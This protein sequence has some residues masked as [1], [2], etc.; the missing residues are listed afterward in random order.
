MMN[1]SVTRPMEFLRCPHA[2]TRGTAMPMD[3]KNSKLRASVR[4]IAVRQSR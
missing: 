1:A 4:L 3:W 2:M